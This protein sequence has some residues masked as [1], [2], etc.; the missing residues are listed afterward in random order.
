MANEKLSLSDEDFGVILPYVKEDLITDI[1]YNGEELWVDHLEKGRYKIEN[2]G[3]T[4][5]W[6]AQFTQKLSNKMNIQCNRSRPFIEAETDTLR[7]SIIHEAVTNTGYSVS[8]RKTPPIRRL[9][10]EKMI[11]EKYC[12]EAIE[13]FLANAVKC[14]FNIVVC[15]LP[16]TGKTEFV[17]YLTKYIPPY[18]KTITIEDN[19]EIR[20]RSIN[21]EKDCVEIKVRDD[22]DYDQAIKL[23]MRQLPTWILI[24]ETRGKEVTELLKALST[25]THCL[26]TLHTDTVRKVPERIKNM[27]KDVN[28]NDIYMFIDMAV[29]IKSEVREGQKIRRYI[30]EVGLI[31]HNIVT[32]ENKVIM[33]YENGKFVNTD[34]PEDVVIKFKDGGFDDP[35]VKRVDD[36]ETNSKDLSETWE[37]ENIDIGVV[38]EIMNE[39]AK[40]ELK[41]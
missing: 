36:Y 13:T 15:G 2:S 4:N 3:I 34:F 20:Y 5:E 8:I 14:G 33:V 23:S 24:A 32:G 22:F 18:Q 38:E 26:T 41:E 29:L 19:L 30:A 40:E 7:V 10:Y 1:N 25:G 21:P 28:T 35:F 39:N 6:I 37:T 17:K 27:S 9:S 16:G 12:D 31:Y 11:G